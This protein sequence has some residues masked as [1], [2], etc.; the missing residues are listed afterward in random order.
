MKHNG[1]HYSL[2]VFVPEA[3]TQDP[4]SAGIVTSRDLV[5]VVFGAFQSSESSWIMDILLNSDESFVS[6]LICVVE[7]LL[8]KKTST[9]AVQTSKPKT[10][11]HELKKID[12]EFVSL[13]EC[14]RKMSVQSLEERMIQYQRDCDNRMQEELAIKTKLFEET[15]I[16]AM[17]LEESAKY[18]EKL[19]I[20]REEM[21]QAFHRKYQTI[22]QHEKDIIEKTDRREK[23][24]DKLAYEHRQQMLQDLQTAEAKT[25]MCKR[26]RMELDTQKLILKEKA[27]RLDS[28]ANQY[29]NDFKTEIAIHRAKLDKQHAETMSVLKE[30]RVRLGEEFK[31]L[32][33]E[34]K[35]V[36][37][38]VLLR[39][40]LTETRE[41]LNSV[42]F[43]LEEARKRNRNLEIQLEKVQLEKNKQ[44]EENISTMRKMKELQE[45]VK[46]Q[47]ETIKILEAKLR[48]LQ[49]E[50]SNAQNYKR[51]YNMLMEQCKIV[52][53]EWET[54][55]TKLIEQIH[56]K[57][58]QW[59][60]L[61]RHLEEE[62]LQQ[63]S[64]QHEIAN[65]QHQLN[66]AQTALD[67]AL[68]P[69]NYNTQ[70]NSNDNLDGSLKEKLNLEQIQRLSEENKNVKL[71]LLQT[72]NEY[73]EHL[74]KCDD[75]EERIRQQLNECENWKKKYLDLE[76]VKDKAT[77]REEEA[78]KLEQELAIT[79]QALSQIKKE[80]SSTIQESKQEREEL[81]QTRNELEQT[82]QLVSG[83]KQENSRLRAQLAQLQPKIEPTQDLLVTNIVQISDVKTEPNTVLQ[84]SSKTLPS[85]LAIGNT[86]TIKPIEKERDSMHAA[87]S[88][89]QASATTSKTYPITE[90]PI[91][92]SVPIQTQSPRQTRFAVGVEQSTGKNVELEDAIEEELD[93]FDH[94]NEEPYL[95]APLESM[96]SHDRFEG[97]QY[98]GD[99]TI[100]K[101]DEVV[102]D[103]FGNGEMDFL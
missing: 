10:L 73:K 30:E 88:S 79:Q 12:D 26:E 16:S 20:A 14:E 97:D 43:E 76:K 33:K 70:H 53:Q 38:Y 87:I 25:A 24:L 81:K 44:D 103:E 93:H 47:V 41:G 42:R 46:S 91:T 1:F 32:E 52:S 36:N 100:F 99:D 61:Q 83:L 15:M 17:R 21:D 67:T 92:D 55:R 7:H 13:L 22:L 69:K 4:T 68:Y 2:S 82:S 86:L 58:E 34:K 49:S 11:D 51:E 31:K 54:E 90:I 60:E 74:R 6:A 56:L 19:V 102:V 63:K 71:Q 89:E 37:D 29:S 9:I 95:N 3:T 80:H 50:R 48:K 40:T 101:R 78:R 65:L 39:E 62:N 8:G 72:Q 35:N 59:E 98:S 18:R 5:D 94:D 23:E 45:T 27:Q 96:Y 84:E 28:L 85:T 77:E 66:T 64:S 75:L 57:E